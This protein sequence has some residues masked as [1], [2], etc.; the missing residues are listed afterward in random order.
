MP[1]PR[2]KGWR[3][4]SNPNQRTAK[5]GLDVSFQKNDGRKKRQSFYRVIGIAIIAVIGIAGLYYALTASSPWPPIL[6]LRH[7]AAAPSCDAARAVGLAPAMQGE[8][9]YYSKHDR[10][11]DGIACEPWPRR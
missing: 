11:K 6:T 10:D 4:Y 9:G 1:R 7:I 5:R 2:P 3:I 8:P